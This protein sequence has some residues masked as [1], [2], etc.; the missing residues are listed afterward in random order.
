MAPR[1]RRGQGLARFTP[2]LPRGDCRLVYDLSSEHDPGSYDLWL[3]DLRDG[4]EAGSALIGHV[5][6]SVR[7]EHVLMLRLWVHPN[8]RR[9]GLGAYLVD[10]AKSVTVFLHG[11]AL[12]ADARP[13]K[14][15]SREGLL[16]FYR[17]SGFT[18]DPP[19]PDSTLPRVRWA[20][21]GSAAEPSA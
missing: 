9:R 5:E 2:P 16:A 8:H 14:G 17:A 12:V 21:A 6:L 20:I 19:M 10:A 7:K 4:D 15:G 1:S 11:G 18:V 13:D 3:I